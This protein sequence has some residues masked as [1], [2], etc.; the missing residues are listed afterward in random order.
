MRRS[1]TAAR[2]MT[3][4]EAISNG[5]PAFKPPEWRNAQTTLVAMAVL[6][7]VVFLGISYLATVARRRPSPRVGALADRRR[8]LRLG[9]A[10]LRAHLSTMGILVLAAQTSFADFPRL[11]SILARDGFMPRRFAYRGERLA[12]NAGIV[13]ARGARDPRRVAFGGRVEALIPLYAIGVFTRSRCPSGMVRHWLTSR[14]PAGGGAP[15]STAPGDG[16]GV[17]AIVFAIAKF[18]SARGSS[19]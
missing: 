19:S 7:G 1:P 16:D 5:A 6:L 15:S 13:V 18:S 11:A 2:A 9:A 10:L 14:D 4:V 8:R 3:G 12:F 17:V